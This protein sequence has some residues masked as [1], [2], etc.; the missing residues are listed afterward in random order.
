MTP[1]LRKCEQL[2]RDHCR[3]KQGFTL[4]CPESGNPLS[5]VALWDTFRDDPESIFFIPPEAGAGAGCCVCTDC[6][7]VDVPNVLPASL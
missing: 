3:S 6:Y 2:L 5:S 4:V 7:K 1:Y